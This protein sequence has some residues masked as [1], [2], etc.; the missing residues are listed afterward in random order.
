MP[1]NSSYPIAIHVASFSIQETNG[2]QILC[3]FLE[4]PSFFLAPSSTIPG[5]LALPR[6]PGGN[7]MSAHVHLPGAPSSET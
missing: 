1:N 5:L 7:G 4:T 6:L 3:T 2:G